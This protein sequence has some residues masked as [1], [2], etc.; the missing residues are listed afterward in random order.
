MQSVLFRNS[1]GL[2]RLTMLKRPHSIGII[3]KKTIYKYNSFNKSLSNYVLFNLNK[4]TKENKKLFKKIGIN[5]AN[6]KLL[7]IKFANYIRQLQLNSTHLAAALNSFRINYF[8]KSSPHK[9]SDE[10]PFR[11]TNPKDQNNQNVPPPNPNKIQILLSFLL[12][13]YLIWSI[14]RDLHNFSSQPPPNPAQIANSKQ[15]AGQ[16]AQSGGHQIN[17]LQ[18]NTLEIAWND[19]V[20]VLLANN[21][22][23]KILAV[24]NSPVI[25]IMLKKD[26]VL[27]G[28][29]IHN[30]HLTMRIDPE[31]F[32]AKLD[33]AQQDLKI[34]PEDRV[35]IVYKENELFTAVVNG[36][37]S[38][39]LL[40][41][42]IRYFGT[43]GKKLQ[44]SQTDLFSGFTKAKYTIVDPHLK[45]GVPNVTFKDVAG[46]HEAKIEVKEFVDYLSQPEK[47]TKLGAKVPKGKNA[48]F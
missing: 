3:E 24:K 7:S 22:V 2:S 29:T 44:S 5:D 12:F 38:L 17:F 31:E 40:F 30:G 4:I 46:L 25:F 33:R 36:V 32:E 20:N 21:L 34:K 19:F 37:I 8:S 1:A 10:N 6:K 35:P 11:N 15:P 9:Q 28:Q 45:S 41:F 13:S 42:I 48:I 47:Y 26:I 23:D 43:L 39:A 18:K 14:G 27:N 16:N